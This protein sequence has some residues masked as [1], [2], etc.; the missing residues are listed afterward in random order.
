MSAGVLSVKPFRFA[1]HLAVHALQHARRSGNGK[2]SAWNRRARLDHCIRW[3][4]RAQ[5]VADGGGVSEG[6]HLYHG[7]LQPYPETT[8]Y[9]IET[10]LDYAH[11]TGD[12]SIRDRAHRMAKW[13][14]SIQNPDGSMPDS[15]FRKK[16]VFDTGQIVFGLVR[17]FEDTGEEAFRVAA[18]Q[19]GDWLVG[20]QDPDGAWRAH[21]LHEIPHTY[22]S[23]VGWS[24]L[25]LDRVSGNARYRDAAAKNA[26]WTLA[27]QQPNGWF[28]HAAFSEAT[29]N[30]PFTHTIAYTLRGLLEMGVLLDDD[31][32]VR[33]ASKGL[34][35]MLPTFSV[36]GLP[37]GTYDREWN[38]DASYTCLTGDAQLAIV[39]M[40]L[41]HL[42][43]DP[44]LWHRGV[45]INRALERH[46]N[47][48][49]TN[50]DLRG[51]LAG[52]AP[53]WGG[54]IHFAYPNW[55]AKFFA[56]SLLTEL[57]LSAEDG[58]AEPGS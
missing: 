13:L 50:P 44:D 32:F 6:Y 20:V 22:Y 18:V 17:A 34:R 12:S 38:G 46:H 55:A 52:S 56:E 54:Y 24:L 7:W 45:A 43:D 31:R 35:G 19:A 27:Q 36:D 26:V 33:A 48:A 39:S 42:E 41:A 29:E 23:R 9:I 4:C 25:A 28:A 30:T 51:A 3:L 11:V 15:Y 1:K 5:D 53:I 14:V 47:L 8:G 40:R 49:T 21:A 2:P 57:R 10:F 37:A 16:M 58:S